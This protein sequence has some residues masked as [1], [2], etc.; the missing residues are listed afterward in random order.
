[1]AT[2]GILRYRFRQ[3]DVVA[4]IS[5]DP[6]VGCPS[7]DRGFVAYVVQGDTAHEKLLELGMHTADGW[8]EVHSGLEAGDQIVTRGVEALA[9]G[10]KVQVS[11]AS[12]AGSASGP[13]SSRGGSSET[14]PV[15]SG[16]RSGDPENRRR[17]GPGGAA[18]STTAAGEA[19]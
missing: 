3:A 7:S 13:V 9:E 16:G 17:R 11:P 4:A 19:P 10:T 8:V 1:L 15:A 2:A 18:S 6:A 14:P 5:D 12:A